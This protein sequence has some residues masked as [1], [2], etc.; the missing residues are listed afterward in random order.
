MERLARLVMHHRRIVSA[1]WV[2]LFVGGLFSVSALSDRWTLD[3][4]LPGQ[5]GD[6]AEQQL[7]DKFDSSTFDTYVA[8]VTVPE[9]ETVLQ[10]QDAVAGVIATAVAAVPDVPLRVVDFASTGDPAFVTDDG[11]STYALIQAPLPVEFGPYIETQF[12]PAIDK[13][14]AAEGFDGS[15]TSYALLGAGG[16]QEEASVLIETLLGAAGALLVL[17]FVFASFLALLPL[18]IAGVSILTTFML[19]LGLTTFSD[20]SII[21]QFL[22]AL[23]GLGVAID[24]SLLL[25]SR[26][27]EERAHGR[28]NEEAVVVAMKTAGHAVV[29]SG[30]TVAISLLALLVVPVPALRSMGLA[31][32]LIPLVSVAVVLTLLPALLSSIGPR[33]D[34]PR[35]RK[36][37]TASR[38]WSAWARLIVRHRFVAT[39]AAMVMLALLIAPVFNLKIGPGSSLESLARSGPRFDT[40]QTLTDGG[41]GTGVLTPVVVL[42]PAADAEGA[43]DAAR[44]VEGVQLAVVG[45]IAG[46]TAVVDVLPTDATLDSDASGVVKDVRS[47][48]DSSD[49]RRR[50]HHRAWPDHRGLLQRG[51]RQVPVRARLDRTDHLHLARANIPIRTAAT[52]GRPAQSAVSR[53][54][55][56][57][58]RVLLADGPRIRCHLR[59]V[60]YRCHQLLAAGGD[61]RVPVRPVDGLRGLH[62]GSN[63][64]GVRPHRRHLDGRDHR[65]RPDWSAGDVGGAD[66]V[67]RLLSTC[68]VSWDRRQGSRHRAGCWHPDRCH[69]RARTNGPCT[70]QHLRP[71]ELVAARRG[72]RASCSSS[73][74]HS[75]PG[76]HPGSPGGGAAAC[77]RQLSRAAL[78]A[79]AGLG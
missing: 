33:V 25:V 63:A 23:I 48:V 7:I 21:V 24:Y 5:P 66:P 41:V 61:L 13:A 58:D 57:V 67:L 49:Q 73:R 14:A 45:T 19:V 74:L 27:R 6:Q 35:I 46:D 11:R 70:G 40:L 60:A 79:S 16:D 31:G 26:W 76:N 17:I 44:G 34:Y 56:R 4:S 77:R 18:L 12:D 8:V 59:R 38:G 54:G 75:L 32:M 52:Q 62:P 43:A 65:D 1:I 69:D 55:V 47:A 29:A 39:A 3:F 36:E 15:M 37:G 28:S 30:V 64:R 2:A 51:L 20:V 9:G 22:I 71:M 78:Q 68:H 72:S 10:N 53:G 50:R 42:V